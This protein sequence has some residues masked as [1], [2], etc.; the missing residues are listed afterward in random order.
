[1]LLLLGSMLILLTW[2]KAQL[3]DFLNSVLCTKLSTLSVYCI[4]SYARRNQNA[5]M[6]STP[7]SPSS[8]F[9]PANFSNNTTRTHCFM[10][11]CIAL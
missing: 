3:M 10:D 8:F 6:L 2:Y 11:A 9:M 1:M 7:I 5:K 4:L